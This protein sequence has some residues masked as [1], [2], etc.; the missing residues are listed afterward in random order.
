[1]SVIYFPFLLISSVCWSLTLTRVIFSLFFFPFYKYIA[2]SSSARMLWMSSVPT[3]K[4]YAFLQRTTVKHSLG[5][6]V[7]RLPDS[8]FSYPLI[9]FALRYRGMN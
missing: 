1:M 3:R 7:H 5:P 8:T 2:N 6:W 4:L 9:P